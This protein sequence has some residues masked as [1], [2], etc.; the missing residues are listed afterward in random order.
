MIK[1]ENECCDC[2]L[3]CLGDRC[4]NRNVRRL[5]CDKCGNDCREL[6]EVDGE[7][8]CDDCLLEYAKRNIVDK[9][10]K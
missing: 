3:P 2:G 7:Q 1:Y 8:L 4:P 6:Y 9:E 5:Y 10:V